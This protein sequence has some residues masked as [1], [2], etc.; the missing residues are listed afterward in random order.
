M[1]NVCTYQVETRN[2]LKIHEW[3]RRKLFTVINNP[4]ARCGWQKYVKTSP[5]EA[6]IV[7]VNEK[8]LLVV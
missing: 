1:E 4:G 3:N 2:E 8:F 6:G 7:H 5:E